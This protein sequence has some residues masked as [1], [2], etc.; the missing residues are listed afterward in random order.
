MDRTPS[1]APASR[2]PASPVPA[3]PPLALPNP[4]KVRL[5]VRFNETDL[6][7]IVHHASY[8]SYMEV[9]R[10][11]WLRRRGITYAAWA[12]SGLHL[13][14]VEVSL[15]YRASSR[16]DDELEIE[17]GLGELRAASLR[18]DYRIVRP[19]DD[20]LCVEGS[21]RLAC[22]DG[23]HALKRIS[24]EMADVFGRP[25]GG[26]DSPGRGGGGALASGGAPR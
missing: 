21:T 8:L 7:G 24:P 1:G 14:V 25:E 2:P 5:R 13:P 18:F 9:A 4:S 22:V 15:K 10:V 19:K 3:A 17:V 6:M 12:E 26:E 11:E 20:R 16:F 23:N